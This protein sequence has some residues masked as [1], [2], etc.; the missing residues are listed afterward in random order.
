MITPEILIKFGVQKEL[1]KKYAS[2]IDNTIHQFDIDDNILRAQHFMAQILHESGKLYYT[3]E[4]ANGAAY[5][6]RKDL[7]NTQVGDGKRFNGRGFIQ[8]TGRANYTTI[9]KELKIDCVN[10]PQ[11]LELPLYAAMSAGWFWNKRGLNTFADNNDLITITKRIN[12]GLNG[13]EE[14]K[15]F[16]DL[17]K[18]IITI[19]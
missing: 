1:A 11:I 7:G 13:F 14:R 18:K 6:G 15:N 17:A 12:G 19:S 16:L 2:A 3:Q 4:I 9:A 8:I 5:E 10:N